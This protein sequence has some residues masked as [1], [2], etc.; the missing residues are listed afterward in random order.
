MSYGQYEEGVF[1]VFRIAMNSVI[2][3]MCSNVYVS[4]RKAK[5][6]SVTN[7][8]LAI[9]RNLGNYCAYHPHCKSGH[10]LN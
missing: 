9:Q 5:E 1:T 6:P 10:H 7:T 4:A 3:G 8:F 2:T